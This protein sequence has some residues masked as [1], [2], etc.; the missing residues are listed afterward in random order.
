V[1][2]NSSKR[3][4]IT[5]ALDGMDIE[6]V[7]VSSGKEAL[8]TLLVKDFAM[9]LLDVNMPIMDGFETATLIRSRPRSEH[10]P[11]L[12]ITSD[13]LD[14]EERLKGYQIGAVDYILS[15]VLPQILRA[16]VAVFADLHRLREQSYRY[17]EEL[18]IKNEKIARQNTILEEGSRMKSEFLANMSHELRT[19]LNAIIGFSELLK[20]G[21]TGKLTKTQLE[22]ISLIYSSGQHLLSLINDILDLSKIEAGKLVLQSAE[23]DITRLLDNT[24][25]LLKD[26]AE[27]NHIQLSLRVEPNFGK[28]YADERKVKQ[29]LYNLVANAVK[30]SHKGGAVRV[31]AFVDKKM[32][33]KGK[34]AN[35]LVISVEDNGIGIAKKDLTKLFQPFAQ[36]DGSLTRHYEGTGL[37]LVIV[38]RLAE[39]HG[40][41]VDVRSEIN[42][43]SCFSFWL[44]MNA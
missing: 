40:G 15:P 8:R 41:G 33:H 30:F 39:L 6:I 21:L 24:L 16:K 27:K 7:T 11:I 9:V 23:I 13:R 36:V 38:K 4:A 3:T 28:I 44:P 5:S 19:P 31:H 22:H 20:D 29:I 34:G 10:L 12:F 25:I 14:D 18:L 2:D 37:G 32:I 26:K 35:A 43:G 17:S 1:D 42:K